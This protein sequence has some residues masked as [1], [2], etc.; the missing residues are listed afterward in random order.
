MFLT[1]TQIADL[2]KLV[3]TT[4]SPASANGLALKTWSG[5]NTGLLSAFLAS[6]LADAGV[7]GSDSGTSGNTAIKVF[8]DQFAASVAATTFGGSS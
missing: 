4:Y 5:A 8:T 3:G 6:A 7:N 1:P 2:N